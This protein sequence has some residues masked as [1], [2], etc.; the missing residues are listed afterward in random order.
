MCC[1]HWLVTSPCCGVRAVGA[2]KGTAGK[3]DVP[4]DVGLAGGRV[5]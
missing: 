1:P 3:E 2:G 4:T 5:C